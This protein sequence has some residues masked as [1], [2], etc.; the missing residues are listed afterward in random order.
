MSSLPRPCLL[1]T[2]QI[3]VHL[4]T[5]SI[6]KSMGIVLNFAGPKFYKAVYVA[7]CEQVSV[8]VAPLEPVILNC[9]ELCQKH[10]Q[11]A[12]ATFPQFVLHP[13]G[14]ELKAEFV[15]REGAGY[16]TTQREKDSADEKD[17]RNMRAM[18][19]VMKN[20]ISIKPKPNEERKN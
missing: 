9:S 11:S 1:T 4:L 8:T 20:I 14:E 7:G 12:V 17:R 16:A 15:V 6:D 10:P 3:K 19:L 13:V 5:V 2:S 18:E